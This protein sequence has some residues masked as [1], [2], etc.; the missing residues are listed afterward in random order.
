MS[1][2]R[3]PITFAIPL[4]NHE[5]IVAALH[6]CAMVGNDNKAVVMVKG[7][8]DDFENFTGIALEDYEDECLEDDDTFSCYEEPTLWVT[9]W[10]SQAATDGGA[11]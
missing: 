1:A 10:P 6:L 3:D 7:V 8:T 4:A 9:L 5:A 11:V 2:P